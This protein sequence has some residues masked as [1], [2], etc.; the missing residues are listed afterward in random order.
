MN[1]SRTVLVAPVARASG[2][3]A[4]DRASKPKRI[5]D[6]RVLF[7]GGQELQIEHNGEIYTL[8]L[9]SKGKLILTK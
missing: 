6:S 9:T 7:D 3:A 8:R 4:C 5:F 2:G 1:E